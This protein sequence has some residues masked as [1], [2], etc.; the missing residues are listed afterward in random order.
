MTHGP[1]GEQAHAS[2]GGH[3]DFAP[4]TELERFPVRVILNELTALL[5]AARHAEVNR[6]EP[7]P[8]A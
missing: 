8:S 5:G 4:S 6:P 7:A 3:A 1:R 2:E